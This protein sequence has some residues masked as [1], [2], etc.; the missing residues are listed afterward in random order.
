MGR[1]EGETVKSVLDVMNPQLFETDPKYAWKLFG[2]RI[3]LYKDTVPHSGFSVLKDWI[4]Q[5]NLDYF[6]L[7]SNVDGQ[8]QKAGFDDRRIR[9]VHGSVHYFQGLYPEKCNTVW[10]NKL[11]G[12]EIVE[13]AERGI[14]PACPGSETP[15][16]PNMYMFHDGSYNSVRTKNQEE[17]YQDFLTCHQNSNIIVFE[18]GA[19]PQVQTL[20][21]KTR[22]L[23]TNFNSHIVRINPGFPKIKPPHI[24]IGKGAKKTLLEIDGHLKGG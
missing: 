14:F 12:K 5:Y 15:A 20:R 18:I 3:Q 9:E 6:I 2:S 11:S 8:F 13:S 1:V 22:H 10:I 23:R 7:T 21:M 24:G 17:K 4:A 19:G 16:R